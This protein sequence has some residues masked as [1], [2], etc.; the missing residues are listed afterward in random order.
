M[1]LVFAKQNTADSIY[2]LT[3]REISEAQESNPDITTQADEEAYSTQLVE[4]ITVLCKGN[5]MVIPKSLQ[6]HAVAWY[7]NYLQHPGKK[8]FETTLRTLMYWK[9]L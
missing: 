9:G 8:H 3:T 7:H 2:P 5:K 6:R 1:N 4:N